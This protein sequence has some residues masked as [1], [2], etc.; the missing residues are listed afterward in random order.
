LP[1]DSFHVLRWL[2]SLVPIPA[3]STPYEVEGV[4]E[5]GREWT[6][7]QVDELVIRVFVTMVDPEQLRHVHT[8]LDTD[9]QQLS[10]AKVCVLATKGVVIWKRTGNF[11]RGAGWTRVT[12]IYT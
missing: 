1:I 2:S 12:K 3:I 10:R 7:T 11:A 6:I 8:S 9:G 5:L 4:L